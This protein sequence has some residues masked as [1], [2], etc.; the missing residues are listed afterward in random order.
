MKFELGL[1]IWLLVQTC[2]AAPSTEQS[3]VQFQDDLEDELRLI[4][5]A[6]FRRPTRDTASD[7]SSGN[8]DAM[9]QDSITSLQRK[10]TEVQEKIDCNRIND[11]EQET[12]QVISRLFETQV[13]TVRYILKSLGN[14]PKLNDASKSSLDSLKAQFESYASQVTN[15]LHSTAPTA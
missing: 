14:S 8:I 12:K 4:E 11:L 7:V 15:C 5:A 9:L 10:I 13:N 2:L 6:V 3:L 1:A